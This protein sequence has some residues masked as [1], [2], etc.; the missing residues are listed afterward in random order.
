MEIS[1]AEL[2][3]GETVSDD[4]AV[5]SDEGE[6]EPPILRDG[7]GIT[8]VE[9]DKEHFGNNEA[10]LDFIKDNYD[11]EGD[12]GYLFVDEWAAVKSI[13][14]P[15]RYKD[16][17]IDEVKGLKYFIC[18]RSLKVEASGPEEIDISGNDGLTSLTLDGCEGLKSLD[19][20]QN[21]N[22]TKL[23]I[24]LCKKITSLDLSFNTVLESVYIY[25]NSQLSSIELG[26]NK[27]NLKS[28]TCT[29]CG[30]KTL[31]LSGAVNIES[32]TCNINPQFETIEG[33][34][35]LQ[36]LKE[37]ELSETGLKKLDFSG[38]TVIEKIDIHKNNS[39]EEVQLGG[40][41][42]LNTI[43][44]Y[45]NKLQTLDLSGLTEL[46]TLDCYKN[47]LSSVTLS[48]N[49]SLTHID[50]K[51]NK[52]SSIDLSSTTALTYL[53]CS[54][55]SLTEIEGI[56]SLTNLESLDCENNSLKSLDLTGLK[57]LKTLYCESNEITELT[58]PDN[59]NLSQIEIDNNK[60]L[61][62]EPGYPIR[63]RDIHE[64][65]S[66]R[67]ATA[68]KTKDNGY[69]VVLGSG[70]ASKDHYKLRDCPDGIEWEITDNGILFKSD[71]FGDKVKLLVY[72]DYFITLDEY[73]NSKDEGNLVIPIEIWNI[74]IS[75]DDINKKVRLDETNFPDP[76]FRKAISEGC[77]HSHGY[78]YVY[79]KEGEEF[80]PGKVTELS[81]QD[82]N[83]KDLTGIKYFVQLE[84]LNVDEN[85]LTSL[86]LSGC[87]ALRKLYCSDNRLTKLDLT[88]L[89]HL[90]SLNCSRNRLTKL[91]LTGLSR[92]EE[93]YCERNRLSSLDL[94]TLS[95]LTTL[96][97][98]ENG[99]SDLNLKKNHQLSNIL[100]SDGYYIYSGDS[101]EQR[102]TV[103]I[104]K[105]R[106]YWV[107]MDPRLPKNP[108]DSAIR[109]TDSDPVVN[110]AES[111]DGGWRW[112]KD[113]FGDKYLRNLIIE[114]EISYGESSF[115]LRLKIS[116]INNESIDKA[117]VEL[118]EENFP[119]KVFRDYL[120]SEYPDSITDGKINVLEVDKVSIYVNPDK[121]RDEEG[122]IDYS[123]T[124]GSLKGIEKLIALQSLKLT[125]ARNLKKIDLSENTLLTLVHISDCGIEWL[126]LTN[127]ESLTSLNV[128]ETPV[129]GIDLNKDCNINI[130]GLEY[131]ITPSA[132]IMTAVETDDG[133]W[134]LPMPENWKANSETKVFNLSESLNGGKVIWDEEKLI[135]LTMTYSYLFK[136][137]YEPGEEY[138][139]NEY[140]TVTVRIT[141]NEQPLPEPEFIDLT[142]ENFPDEA[143]RNYL[144]ENYGGGK[145]IIDT[146]EIEELRIYNN[147]DSEYDT[148][149]SLTD[150]RGIEKL[151]RLRT[152][153]LFNLPITKLD[154][155]K[156]KFLAS[157]RIV[158]CN[159]SELNIGDEES[160][161]ECLESCYVDKAALSKLETGYCPRLRSLE[162][163]GSSI[164]GID[165]KK[166]TSLRRLN[167]KDNKLKSLDVSNCS[168]LVY[169]DVSNTREGAEGMNRIKSINLT[170]L[171]DLE[172]LLLNGNNLS[173]INL[174]GLDKLSEF[175]I[176]GGEEGNLKE[177]DLN[178]IT[179]LT[180]LSITKTLFYTT[181]YDL[182]ADDAT[183][184]AAYDKLKRRMVTS[185][186]ALTVKGDFA[187]MKKLRT[188]F[189]EKVTVSSNSGIG[190]DL[191]KSGKL[192]SLTLAALKVEKLNLKG[193]TTLTYLH[194]NNIEVKDLDVSGCI[195]LDSL[196]ISNM[197][198]ESLSVNGMN[199]L[200]HLNCT[201]NK[202]KTLDLSGVP[203]LQTLKCSYNELKDLDLHNNKA[204]KVLDCMHNPMR[205]L[206]TLDDGSSSGKETEEEGEE[207]VPEVSSELKELV[208]DE[209]AFTCLDLTDMLALDYDE[210]SYES[211]MLEFSWD[212]DEI[213]EF[214]LPSDIVRA[215]GASKGDDI[216][217]KR[218]LKLGSP[219]NKF[220]KSK[221]INPVLGNGTLTNEGIVYEIG[222]E[223]PKE[224]SYEYRI[225]NSLGKELPNM[226]VTIK[227]YDEHSDDRKE[228]EHTDDSGEEDIP[229]DHKEEDI[230][231][232]SGEEGLTDDHK[233][234]EHPDDHKE[235][236][237]STAPYDPANKVDLSYPDGENANVGMSYKLD[238][239]S[240]LISEN[241]IYYGTT[242][243]Y[244]E[245]C[246]AAMAGKNVSENLIIGGHSVSV[247]YTQYVIYDGR[248]KVQM[249]G[250]TKKSV[251]P[252]KTKHP[253][254]S[255]NVI[256]DGEEVS[257]QMLKV[258][259]KN[260]KN[261]ALATDSKAPYMRLELIT[262]D[263]SLA[264]E[265]KE[266][267]KGSDTL[268]FNILPASLNYGINGTRFA[269]KMKGDI[270]SKIPKLKYR[271]NFTD[272]PSKQVK[273][274]INRDY[275]VEQKPE[276]LHYLILT[277][278]NNFTGIFRANSN[279]V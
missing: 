136:K 5:S 195:Q 181:D 215:S 98:A 232:D 176:D 211:E 213:L 56:G 207:Y 111:I 11:T 239:P 97:C 106:E 58:V 224:I 19:L 66:M 226:K 279:R 8:G 114:R 254:I 115:I 118:N 103:K 222:Q 43:K 179:S 75:E 202:L 154:L 120:S 60:L 69:L 228:E 269:C 79:C 252:S 223:I 7:T 147:S 80:Q 263:K 24:T 15:D 92:L 257:P 87:K 85:T 28:F 14:I 156:N 31:D 68:S 278:K 220:D 42:S 256:I 162:L 12:D 206:V 44:L 146:A 41:T 16:R 57:K 61:S 229:D 186:D 258:K 231:D 150:M 46:K 196:D 167:L 122:N 67:I 209:C 159:L 145:G 193:N 144:N 25:Q 192:Y 189:L 96:N 133:K 139:R 39:L 131:T 128:D 178:K 140:F 99:L 10:F 210:L 177:V 157:I 77:A 249:S 245:M 95:S 21:T 217:C 237:S 121:Y 194:L 270:I 53:D 110:G 47:E 187:A 205:S 277:G 124:L 104:V 113:I 63:F 70:M 264:G 248:A 155:S 212:D 200:K 20:K 185:G 161:C 219:K 214:V 255:V 241:G 73:T 107:A 170:G 180:S 268:K 191:S 190:L 81:L 52:L 37:V 163:P 102:A 119:D 76:E 199:S 137:D 267:F 166:N 259:F 242:P 89:Y 82:R 172:T 236:V 117:S 244:R 100:S 230:S 175:S 59:M 274:K 64:S 273:L 171:K 151:N 134:T 153:Y 168:K 71:P 30:V 13:E 129:L 260:N 271:F 184:Y 261:A 233:K 86:D 116:F 201:Y 164:S 88:G 253:S 48:G 173:S 240:N 2:E 6:D 50:I 83:I 235:D 90:D 51:N 143:F 18:L 266:A 74:D 262:E 152:L 38:N 78:G 4:V 127:Q 35:K 29:G 251:K 126:D 169:L 108:K 23:R 101:L 174:D 238:L 138:G 276:K 221:V 247:R 9:I 142:E 208:L 49:T 26:A 45:D 36:A 109:Y 182:Y 246:Q 135:P 197:G 34:N 275:E 3:S 148:L 218:I 55:N 141:N 158:N 132:G 72:L 130:Y 84:I 265:F 234:E 250:F 272:A 94:S 165:L 125:G 105:D 62:I 33:L 22:L 203:G 93:L 123:K 91:D 216:S 65:M 112:K 17:A 32:F 198:I 40:N 27:E 227:G 188:L 204:L 149:K 225:D 54:F 243:E 183:S 160:S 1:A